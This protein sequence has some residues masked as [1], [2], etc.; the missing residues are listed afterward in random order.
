MGPAPASVAGLAPVFVVRF[1]STLENMGNQLKTRITSALLVAQGAPAAAG[2]PAVAAPTR[3]VRD[4]D[5]LRDLG[6]LAR[7]E[8]PAGGAR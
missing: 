6:V 8:T 1:P 4:A 5:A 3:L 2:T 7:L